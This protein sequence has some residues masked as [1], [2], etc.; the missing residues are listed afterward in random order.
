MHPEYLDLSLA[1]C[2]LGGAVQF[3]KRSRHVAQVLLANWRENQ[4]PPLPDEE[5]L[6]NDGLEVGNLMAHR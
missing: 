2:A 5:R 4:A 6:A 1:R 3:R